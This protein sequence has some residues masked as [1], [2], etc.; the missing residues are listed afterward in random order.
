MKNIDE[1]LENLTLYS[2][3]FNIPF[4]NHATGK[5]VLMDPVVEM[6]DIDIEDPSNV[7]IITSHDVDGEKKLQDWL[8]NPKEN[9]FE[10]ITKFI[11][12]VDTRA[13]KTIWKKKGINM[14]CPKEL[15]KSSIIEYLKLALIIKKESH[16]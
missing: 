6:F 15:T 14:T 1:I 2:K 11:N 13:P 8:W 5:T 12:G 16:D 4:K 3:N 10:M 9:C 7:V